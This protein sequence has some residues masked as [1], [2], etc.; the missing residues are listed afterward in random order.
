MYT[1]IVGKHWVSGCPFSK[2]SHLWGFSNLHDSGSRLT[3]THP[4]G[5]RAESKTATTVLDD[6]KQKL[7]APPEKSESRH[8]RTPLASENPL[9][10]F[11]FDELP[12]RL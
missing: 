10:M 4:A 2:V 9:V 7:A 5:V 6:D 12:T 1:E 8:S 11:P 3:G